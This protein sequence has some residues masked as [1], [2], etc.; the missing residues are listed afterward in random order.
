DEHRS[1]GVDGIPF[2]EYPE[3]TMVRFAHFFDPG[4]DNTV[5]PLEE[6][7]FLQRNREAFRRPV[8]Q[9]IKVMVRA[10]NLAEDFHRS[11]YRTRYCFLPAVVPSADRHLPFRVP[12]D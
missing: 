1:P 3:E 11:V 10:S 9:R 7:E 6:V 2:E 12:C 8:R 4:D 5:E